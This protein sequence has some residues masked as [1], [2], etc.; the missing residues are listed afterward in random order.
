M[1]EKASMW[2]AFGSREVWI[3]DPESVT[4]VVRRAHSEPVFLSES[5]LLEGRELL[6]GFS[7][8]VWRLFRR[9]RSSV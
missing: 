9:E 5:D 2:L 1:S 6:L 3:L 4:A 8:E 7:V